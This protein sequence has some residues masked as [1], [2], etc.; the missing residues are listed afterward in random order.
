MNLD[1]GKVYSGARPKSVLC[2]SP[3]MLA[4]STV[5]S[6][7]VGIYSSP[8]LHIA[9]SLLSWNGTRVSHNLGG[10]LYSH[11]IKRRV[12]EPYKRVINWARS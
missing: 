4:D 9:A 8:T 3:L 10:R 1:G 12:G 6:C 5:L 11:V 2:H 7:I